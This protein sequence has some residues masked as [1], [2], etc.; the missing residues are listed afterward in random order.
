MSKDVS[1]LWPTLLATPGLTLL[2][3]LSEEATCLTSQWLQWNLSLTY[4]IL[5]GLEI[6][7]FINNHSDHLMKEYNVLYFLKSFKGTFIASTKQTNDCPKTRRSEKER[8]MSN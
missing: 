6:T 4:L 5:I 1:V 8:R 3:K 7:L 2:G